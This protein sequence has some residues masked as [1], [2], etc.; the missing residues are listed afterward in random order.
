MHLEIGDAILTA[1]AMR[2]SVSCALDQQP[3]KL[4]TPVI[5]GSHLHRDTF[6]GALLRRFCKMVRSQTAATLR[7][8][9]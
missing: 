9:T 3:S 2:L 4:P 8:H 7:N 6:A 5:E 1:S